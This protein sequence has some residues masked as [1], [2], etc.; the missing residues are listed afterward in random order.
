MKIIPL[1]L[2]LG[3]GVGGLVVPSVPVA[4]EVGAVDMVSA[5]AFAGVLHPD[6]ALLVS[7][8][9]TNGTGLPLDV[10][11]A[12]VHVS[13]SKMVTRK[14]VARWLAGDMSAAE[15]RTGDPLGELNIGELGIGQSRFFSITVPAA[16]LAFMRGDSGVFPLEIRL[17]KGQESSITQ[18][19]VISWLPSSQV[20]QVSLALAAPLNAPPSSSG[21]VDAEILD[22][23]TSPGGALYDQL[24]TFSGHTIAIGVDPMIVASL[25]LLGESASLSTRNWRERL[26]LAPNDTFLLSYA[27]SDQ[28]LLRQAGAST[29][30]GPLSF[31]QP[32]DDS[33]SPDETVPPDDAAN[34]PASVAVLTPGSLTAMST[35]LDALA[36]PA[37][38][39]HSEGDL[40]FLSAGGFTRTLLSSSE[41]SGNVLSTPNVTVN[42]RQTTVSDDQV[43]MLLRAAVTANSDSEWAWAVAALT[44][45]LA[46]TA[47]QSPGATLV[48]TLGRDAS[49]DSRS[50]SRTLDVIESLA[51]VDP[52]PF[53]RVLEVDSVSG[54]IDVPDDD[55][56]DSARVSLTEDLLNSEL[57]LTKFSSVVDDP[58]LVTGPQRLHLLALASA[59]WA[60]SFLGWE[61][62]VNEHLSQNIELLNSVSLLESSSV[63]LLQEKGNLPIAVRNELDF[64]V[65]VF[66]TVRAE[67]AILSVP[68]SRVK[69]TIE[70]NSQAKA[71][72]P[73]ESI[74]NGEVRTTVSLT[75]PTGV[76]ISQP[77]TIVLNVQAGWET[78]ATVV[79]AAIVFMLFV[80][81]IW[82]TVLR[83]RALR[84]ERDAPKKAHS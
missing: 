21:L 68:K 5:P 11:T 57:N 84:K 42:E 76:Q 18:R 83:R 78:T 39:V 45:T 79:V 67:R 77:S 16:K 26:E 53:S 22:S 36:W 24:E 3:L 35:T 41:V 74:A 1:L 25:N 12:T 56:E 43:S 62:A 15:S 64:P 65:T 2:A 50:I 10:G 44:A 8:T 27:D 72:I 80:A 81:G 71:S 29:P 37:R 58:T 75:S 14:T 4:P 7:G 63:N 47:T 13:P 28:L 20:P 46:V 31:P 82:R 66:V 9:I 19:S 52:V 60:S 33:P 48:A 59:T 32:E 23:L 69:L 40:D 6:Q 70:A 55:V 34:L 17:T 30:L 38:G 51:W 61:D 54:S 73:V 49:P